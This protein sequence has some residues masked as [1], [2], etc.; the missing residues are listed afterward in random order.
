L[1]QS[2]A[3]GAPD[4]AAYHALVQRV[5]AGDLTVDFRELRLACLKASDCQPR[6]TKKDLAE[7][8]LAI[9]SGAPATVVEIAAKL[10]QQGFVN[11]EAHATL[12]SVYPKLNEPAKA[13]FH[14]DVT[15][16]LVRSIF[17]SGDGKTRETAFQIICDREEYVMMGALGLPYFGYNNL[18]VP[19]EDGG[20]KYEKREVVDPKTMKPI[21]DPKTGKET[22]VFFNVDAFSAKSRAIDTEKIDP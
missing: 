8:N 14:L 16:E 3:I 9:Q 21:R 22:V 2:V 11:I 1:G 4:D 15:T 6:G 5:K 13:K 17:Q 10:V 12:A 20:H 7:M 19:F 18:V